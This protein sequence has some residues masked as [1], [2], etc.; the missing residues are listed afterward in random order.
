MDRSGSKIRVSSKCLFFPPNVTTKELHAN[1]L[2]VI[3]HVSA[4]PI[5]KAK[6]VKITEG[7]NC[8]S[9]EDDIFTPNYKHKC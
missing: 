1:R 9:A 3:G 6:Q 5:C 2:E 8:V 7:T 4:C